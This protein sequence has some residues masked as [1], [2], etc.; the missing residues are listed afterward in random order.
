MER[1][2]T[3]EELEIIKRG[4]IE[5]FKAG[6]LLDF[7]L[8]NTYLTYDNKLGFNGSASGDLMLMVKY[9]FADEYI[10]RLSFLIDKDIEKN[11]IKEE[12]ENNG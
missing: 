8:D 1:E 5:E 2:R 10:N 9:L 11:V 4:A 3:Y 6:S 12:E 7:I